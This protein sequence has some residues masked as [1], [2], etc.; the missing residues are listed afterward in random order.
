[1]KQEY[2]VDLGVDIVGF[3][4]LSSGSTLLPDTTARIRAV[5]QAGPRLSERVVGN[6]DSNNRGI[7][8]LTACASS[9]M[10]LPAI[11]ASSGLSLM[12]I[13]TTWM[14][15]LYSPPRV[16]RSRH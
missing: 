2:L 1:M 4:D 11:C 13:L 15:R 12:S 8:G 9:N 14:G 3:L 7:I 16:R 6:Q 5:I 10:D